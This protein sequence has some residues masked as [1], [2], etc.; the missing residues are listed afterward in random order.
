MNLDTNND[1]KFLVE[2]NVVPYIDVML[3]LLIIFMITSPLIT[4]GIKVDLPD[5]QAES[6]ANENV[7][8]PVVISVDAD[9]YYYLDN[10]DDP[11]QQFDRDTLISAVLA[12][13]KEEPARGVMIRG[14]TEVRYGKVVSIMAILQQSGVTNVGLVTEMGD[15]EEAY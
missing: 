13:H 7:K 9:G 12:L 1:S 3:V 6:L 15:E 4:Q 5:A 11:E 14:D 8:P 2:M 10:H